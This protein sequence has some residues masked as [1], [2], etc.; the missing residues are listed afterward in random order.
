MFSITFF[1]CSFLVH[2]MPRDYICIVYDLPILLR[3]LHLALCYVRLIVIQLYSLIYLEFRHTREHK[4]KL[5]C[6]WIITFCIEFNQRI[7]RKSYKL[8]NQVC[9]VAFN[10]LNRELVFKPN[11]MFDTIRLMLYSI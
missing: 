11:A 1:G 4:C 6:H 10:Q 8:L 2:Y 9:V 7:D 5:N 3:R